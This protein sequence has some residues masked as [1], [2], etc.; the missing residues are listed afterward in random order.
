MNNNNTRRRRGVSFLVIAAFLLIPTIFV[1]GPMML[2]ATAETVTV[3]VTDKERVQR[4][5]GGH[6]LIFTETE[7]FSIEDSLVFFTFDGSDKYG[8][9][10]KGGT[11]KFKV[12]GWRNPLTSSYRT[13]VEVTKVR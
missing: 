1:G 2:R 7:T 3:T 10:K 12:Y 6:Y 11:Y 4:A 13:I 8:R 9:I 5:E